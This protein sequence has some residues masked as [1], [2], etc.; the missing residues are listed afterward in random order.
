MVVLRI[1]NAK[2]GRR[3]DFFPI[4]DGNR[5]RVLWGDR[6]LWLC[7]IAAGTVAAGVGRTEQTWT[8]ETEPL[9]HKGRRTSTCNS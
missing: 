9:K 8:P 6:Q 1:C 5:P 7:S 2:R 4:E 3:E